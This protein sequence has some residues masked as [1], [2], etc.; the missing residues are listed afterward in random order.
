MGTNDPLRRGW[1]ND[2]FYQRKMTHAERRDI[3]KFVHR[4]AMKYSNYN[5]KYEVEILTSWKRGLK[6]DEYDGEK[7]RRNDILD[8]IADNGS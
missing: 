6:Q 8:E 3:L 2:K 5:S 7:T 1:I 4:K